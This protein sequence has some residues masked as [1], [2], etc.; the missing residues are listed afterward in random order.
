MVPQFIEE[1]DLEA[2][3]RFPALG[4]H[5]ELTTNG[6]GLLWFQARNARRRVEELAVVCWAVF[7]GHRGPFLAPMVTCVVDDE[8][9]R[10]W[11][12]GGRV[13]KEKKRKRR[14]GRVFGG[15]GLLCP[16]FVPP[17]Y[18]FLFSFFFV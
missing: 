6:V 8:E 10:W 5:P 18:F 3:G 17:L 1:V 7:R 15:S 9:D 13:R 11:S 2:L 4:C 14:E 12:P 16:K